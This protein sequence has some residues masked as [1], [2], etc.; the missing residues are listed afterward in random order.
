[1]TKQQDD[2]SKAATSEAETQDNLEAAPGDGFEFVSEI[3]SSGGGNK[4]SKYDWGAYPAPKDGLYA[5]KFYEVKSA[6]PLYASIKKYKE[7]LEADGEPV[8]EFT[9]RTVKDDKTDTVLGC[10]VYREK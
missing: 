4:T 5:N 7:K 2:K 8:P 3:P 10:R 1:M 9:I 6:K